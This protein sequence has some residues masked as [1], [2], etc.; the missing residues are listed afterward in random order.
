GHLID[1]FP[2][3][4]PRINMRSAHIA[5]GV[6]LGLILIA[7]LL[8]RRTGGTQ[9]PQANKGM[10][11]KAAVGVHHLLYLMMGVTVLVGVACVWIR[12]DNLFNL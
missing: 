9:L 11:D 2:K 6:L 1:F 3:G 10:A 8:W 5:C 7:R 12:G 4:A